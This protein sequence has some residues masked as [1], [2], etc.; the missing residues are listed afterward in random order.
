[1]APAAVAQNVHSQQWY[2]DAMQMDKVWK[3][4]RGEGV[5]VAVVDSGVKSTTASLRGQ[6]LPGK[7]VS[8]ASGTET[9]DDVGHGT[10]MAEL[11]AGTGRDG[12]L[13][14]LAPEAEIIP[15]RT[16]LSQ[17]KEKQKEDTLAKAIRAAADTDAQIINLSLGGEYF[18]PQDESAVKYAAGKGKLMFAATGN[19]GAGKNR[20]EYPANYE[21][22]VGVGAT[23]EAGTVT[24]FSGSGIDVDLVAPGEDLPS[25]CDAKF[26]RYCEGSKGTSHAT[27]IASASAALIW[28]KHPD[29]TANQVLRVLIGT[30]GRASK[31][32][33]PSKYIGHGAVRPRMNLVEGKGD[34]GAPRENPLTGEKT[35]PAKSPSKSTSS[36]SDKEDAADKVKVADSSGSDDNSQLWTIL[37]AGAVVV[38]LGGGAIGIVR[39]RRR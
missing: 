4:S 15:I 9:S 26:Q 22:V 2:L 10:T 32:E 11:I 25:W 17:S 1:L 33:T 6:V 12:G 28:S 24:K 16:A 38:V 3:A 31:N 29:W 8:G 20:L 19:D 21:E 27:A 14:G 18:T 7:N 36:G 23:D 35:G 39:M 5:K 37:G 13:K 30:A 34:P